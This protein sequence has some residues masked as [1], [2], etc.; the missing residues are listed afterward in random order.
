ME[1]A[2]SKLSSLIQLSPKTQP[3]L[4]REPFDLLSLVTWRHILFGISE[5]VI[6]L[7]LITVAFC[8]SRGV[9]VFALWLQIPAKG[10]GLEHIYT[11]NRSYSFAPLRPRRLCSGF[12][13]SSRR[14]KQTLW[15]A[16]TIAANV[17]RR[18]FRRKPCR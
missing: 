2:N 3:L 8:T 14:P 13:P 18:R 6:H 5:V 9:H 11:C 1:I 12:L 16:R 4:L 17:Q 7:L 15:P 10:S